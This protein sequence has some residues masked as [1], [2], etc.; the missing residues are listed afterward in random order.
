MCYSSPTRHTPL[1]YGEKPVTV[2]CVKGAGQVSLVFNS[3]SKR[4]SITCYRIGFGAGRKGLLDP[5]K[6][7]QTQVHSGT[8]SFIQDA[9]ILALSSEPH[10]IQLRKE[11]MEECD[12]L[13]G[14]L[15]AL[16]LDSVHAE[17]T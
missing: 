3:L 2:L 12:A 17:A 7:I 4:N 10:V 6:K 9:A 11:Y 5:F 8:A 15:Q 1:Y 14:S 16:G 13:V